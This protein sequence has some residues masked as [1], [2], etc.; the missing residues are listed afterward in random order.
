MLDKTCLAFSGQ[1]LEASSMILPSE[2]FGTFTPFPT[3]NA[4]S[5]VLHQN[6]ICT[7]HRPDPFQPSLRNRPQPDGR[8]KQLSLNPVG[9]RVEGQA[10]HLRR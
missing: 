2:T 10:V 6:E 4:A 5:V 7:K 9:N 1:R 3:F 8:F